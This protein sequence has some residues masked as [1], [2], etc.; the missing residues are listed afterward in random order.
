MSTST[1]E[2]A[3]R[4]DGDPERLVG[5]VRDVPRKALIPL[6]WI[7]AALLALLALIVALVLYFALRGGGSS[8]AGKVGGVAAAPGRQN[9]GG[10]LVGGGNVKAAQA[11]G[12]FVAVT[13][14]GTV[15]FAENSATLT[16]NARKV[17]AEAAVDIKYFRPAKVILTGYTDKVAGQPLNA[18][19]SKQ[20]AQAVLSAVHNAVGP[21]RTA[22]SFKAKG[23]SDPIAPNATGAGRQDNRRV[24]ITSD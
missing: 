8:N 10:G 1:E 24:T 6:W 11:T 20:R 4:Y 5:A 14:Y 7:A 12:P 3:A 21:G 23:E 18:K 15:L 13:G 22:Y 16:A 9:P 19:L 17:I 2:R